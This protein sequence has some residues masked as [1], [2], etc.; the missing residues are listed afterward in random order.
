MNRFLKI[1]KKK[2]EIQGIRDTHTT[3]SS[4]KMSN[5]TPNER[6]TIIR[7]IIQ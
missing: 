2:A 3:R 1:Q 7:N 5:T 4:G 6:I